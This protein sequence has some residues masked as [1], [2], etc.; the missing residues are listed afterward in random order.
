MAHPDLLYHHQD[1]DPGIQL[2]VD[3]F[4][5][6]QHLGNTPREVIILPDGKID[7]FLS[8]SENEPFQITLLGLT[9]MPEQVKLIPGRQI[10]AISFNPL[11]VEYILQRP[12]NMLLNKG[13]SLAT[14]FWGFNKDDLND[15]TQFCK[16]AN[17]FTLKRFLIFKDLSL[18]YDFLITITGNG[19]SFSTH[20]CWYVGRPYAVIL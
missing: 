19:L 2:Y 5:H 3:G 15:F 12:V 9:A 1:P 18:S 10:F 13:I 14:D 8:K 20:T 17:M 4:W 16:K 11:A 6:L 7:L